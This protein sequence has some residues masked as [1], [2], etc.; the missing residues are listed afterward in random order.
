METRGEKKKREET[1]RGG[2]KGIFESRDILRKWQRDAIVGHNLL[3]RVSGL[4][5]C[6][7]LAASSEERLGQNQDQGRCPDGT[8]TESNTIHLF[9]LAAPLG[10]AKIPDASI[11]ID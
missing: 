6:V 10:G 4:A 2:R 8:S 9:E 7:Q 11:I 3:P 1:N 5:Q